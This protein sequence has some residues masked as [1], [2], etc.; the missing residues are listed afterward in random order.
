[1][2]V[3]GKHIKECAGKVLVHYELLSPP[4][5]SSIRSNV[6]HLTSIALITFLSLTYFSFKGKEQRKGRERIEKR[7]RV[8]RE[9]ER[10][11]WQDL[12]QED[13]SENILT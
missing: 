11:R 13:A 6:I 10:N 8:E 9:I 4:F 5:Y 1:M 2:V 7:E 12:E 3:R